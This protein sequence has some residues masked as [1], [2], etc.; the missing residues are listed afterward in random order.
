[1]KRIV[2]GIAPAAEKIMSQSVGQV[3]GEGSP[4]ARFLG[5]TVNQ[6]T[7]KGSSHIRH[8]Q[9][10]VGFYAFTALDHMRAFV[11]LLK[12][13]RSITPLATLTRG[14][15]EAFAKANYLLDAEIGR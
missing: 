4:A 5:D 3:P 12:T 1:M 15:V 7:L 6:P 2:V 9:L 11:S 14:A 10:A 13:R 8:A